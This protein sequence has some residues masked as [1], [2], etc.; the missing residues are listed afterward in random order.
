MT[1]YS[2]SIIVPVYNKEEYLKRCLKSLV[3]QSYDNY[4]IVLVNDGSSDKSASICD[5]YAKKYPDIK[6]IHKENGGLIS[7]WKAGV[8]ASSGEYITFVDSDDWIDTN[9]LTEMAQYLTGSDSELIL[10]D[11]IIERTFVKGKKTITQSEPVFQRLGEGEYLR[12]DIEE[13][14]IPDILGNEHRLIATSR[15]MKL[16]SRRLIEKNM[17][18]SD[19]RIKM[20]EDSTIIIPVI[21]DAQRIYN[22]DKKAYYHYDYVMS[23]MVHKYDKTMFHNMKLLYGLLGNMLKEKLPG[24]RLA[25]IEE[26]L[27]REFIFLMLLVIKNEAR[28]EDAAYKKNIK[29]ICADE[30]I[31]AVMA[32]TKDSIKISDMSNRLVYRVLKA[33]DSFNIFLLRTAMKVYY[34]GK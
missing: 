4:E 20:A 12:A 10:S 21:I 32:K 11:Y 1:D 3:A 19:E 16:I 31:R 28:N 18:Y 8:T 14:I 24:E 23:S 7:A 34:A 15:C 9:M 29:E 5:S 26:C 27:D 17:H 6:V 33:P 22:M 25:Q 13:K 2:I 30:E